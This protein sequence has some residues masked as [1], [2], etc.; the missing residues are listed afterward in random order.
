MKKYF[1]IFTILISSIFS[2]C[3]IN[4]EYIMVQGNKIK[5]IEE[6]TD[7]DAYRS[8]FIDYCIGKAMYD[9][10]HN[11]F[12]NNDNYPFTLWKI[13]YNNRFKR[14]A[15][16]Q[17][18]NSDNVYELITNIINYSYDKAN[19]L[20]KKYK[21]SLNIVENYLSPEDI[22]WVI[23]NCYSRVYDNITEY[24]TWEDRINNI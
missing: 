13:T 15:K 5:Y 7:Y 17:Y 12:L 2:S 22:S 3:N 23:D 6:K 24:D 18:N 8:A 11:S 10:L 1:I 19:N 21:L 14:Y 9:S 4:T 20:V 16:K